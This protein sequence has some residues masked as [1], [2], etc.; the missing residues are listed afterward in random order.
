MK[1]KYIN[2]KWLITI[3]FVVGTIVFTWILQFMPLILGLDV[4]NTSVSSFDF[5]GLFF[6]IGGLMPT[7]MGTI[8]VLVFYKK[9]KILDFLKRCFV[10]NV[11][12][13][14]AIGIALVLIVIETTVTQFISKGFGAENLGFEG[15]ILIGQQ[16]WMFFYF[17][18]WGLISGPLSEEIG[19]R[20]FLTDQ[21]FS[22]KRLVWYPIVIGAIWGIWHL[23]LF[24]YPSQ[25]QNEWWNMNPLLGIG[26]IVNCITNALVYNSIY[27]FS[28]RKIFPIFFLHMFEN[29]IMTG[30]MI[31][32]FSDTYK[33]VV[34]PV[35]IVLDLVFYFI[36][37]NLPVYKKTV[38]EITQGE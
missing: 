7:L 21:L 18:F 1:D 37:T 36:F 26:F 33:M 4:E 24:F 8:F 5:A 35:S 16:P 22:K 15:L 38:E 6:T 19:W 20:G 11:R 14:I 32:P 9:E 12:S 23:P 29:I 34:I 28:K 2:H 30:A 25:I 17:L 10:P 31:Y 27:V 3:L 13:A